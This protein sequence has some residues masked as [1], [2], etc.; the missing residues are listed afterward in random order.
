MSIPETG[1][2]G[3]FAPFGRLG[4]LEMKRALWTAIPLVLAGCITIPSPPP[5]GP[6]PVPKPIPPEVVAA[7]PKGI[8][9]SNVLDKD[10]CYFYLQDGTPYPVVTAEMRKAGK[11]D[12]PYCVK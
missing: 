10:G 8:P 2:N 1:A 12:V 3:L 4:E 9:Q 5:P 11:T 6:Q 7:L